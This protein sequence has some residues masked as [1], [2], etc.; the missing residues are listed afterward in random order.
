MPQRNTFLE[1]V[2][3]EGKNIPNKETDASKLLET[4]VKLTTKDRKYP[5]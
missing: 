5:T 2:K 3:I 4:I 1:K